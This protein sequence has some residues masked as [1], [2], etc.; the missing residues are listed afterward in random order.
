MV[1]EKQGLIFL[2]G[3]WAFIYIYV[4]YLK[5]VSNSLFGLVQ[6][7]SRISRIVTGHHWAGLCSAWNTTTGILCSGQLISN[8]SELLCLSCWKY[9]STQRNELTCQGT[10]VWR[11]P[12]KMKTKIWRY[13]NNW[14]GISDHVSPYALPMN[15][16]ALRGT[17]KGTSS[18]QI[19]HIWTHGF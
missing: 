2:S 17:K 5:P 3:V 16:L 11:L 8:C 9:L 6:A 12:G 13:N 18:L 19:Q 1:V 10:S 15:I 4:V 14:V 7:W